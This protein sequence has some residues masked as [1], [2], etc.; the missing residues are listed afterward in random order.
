M[1][2]GTWLGLTLVVVGCAAPAGRRPPSIE[3][4]TGATVPA[5]GAAAAAAEAEREASFA[6][7]LFCPDDYKQGEVWPLRNFR[8]LDLFEPL[9]PLVSVRE[10]DFGR[11][12]LNTVM[13]LVLLGGAF[14][15]DNDHETS[16]E[17]GEAT[18]LGVDRKWDNYPILWG[19]MALAAGASFLPDGRADRDHYSWA[20]RLDRLTVLALGLGVSSLEVELLRPVFDRTR[21]NG[22]PGG[23]RPSG[24]AATAFAAAAFT[25][26]VLRETL[27]PSEAPNLPL[28][29]AY[30]VACALPYLGAF[31]VSLARVHGEKH[32]LTDVLLGGAIGALTTHMFYAWSFLRD[33]A[34]L[35]W[36]DT[37]SWSFAPLPG[38]LQLAVRLDF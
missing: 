33:E 7:D 4:E 18:W 30:E 13:P 23:S 8:G 27:R 12:A 3:A 28:R 20:L 25:S 10:G 14:A 15:L 6:T 21:P 1:R 11:L 26:D 29:L 38:G 5:P 31:Y 2:T 24:H 17:L 35:G 37:V 32:Y 16:I 34:D 9:A 36:L 19:S 22:N